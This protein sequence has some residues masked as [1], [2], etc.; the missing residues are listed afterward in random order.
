MA[1]AKTAKYVM[2]KHL[3][4]RGG[5]RAHASSSKRD[6][7]QASAEGGNIF[8]L[9]KMQWIRGV[10]SSEANEYRGMTVFANMQIDL[11]SH[12][13]ILRLEIFQVPINSSD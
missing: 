10:T 9:I 2:M 11:C 1:S 8:F 7:S 3:L 4:L 5:V 12:S 13:S 6:E